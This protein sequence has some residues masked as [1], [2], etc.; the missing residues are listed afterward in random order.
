[1]A[2]NPAMLQE[3]M[4]NSGGVSSVVGWLSMTREAFNIYIYIYVD[5]Y[6]Y[7]FYICI[8]RYI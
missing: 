8:Y 5:I 2:R 7:I 1:V 4:R 6:I 3:L